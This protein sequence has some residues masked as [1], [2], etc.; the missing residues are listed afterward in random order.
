MQPLEE[1]ID[2][3]DWTAEHSNYSGRSIGKKQ[4]KKQIIE[5]FETTDTDFA[6]DLIYLFTDP[7]YA[8]YTKEQKLE[9]AYKRIQE[10]KDL[11][12][13]L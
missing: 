8:T 2:H 7:L 11:I 4:A 5:L 13:K 3:L 6:N 1:I 12:A 10:H 9:C